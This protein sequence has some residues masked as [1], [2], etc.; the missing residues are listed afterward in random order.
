MGI[1]GLIVLSQRSEALHINV[2]LHACAKPAAHFSQSKR[3]YII[4]NNRNKPNPSEAQVSNSYLPVP[5]TCNKA[6]R[7][8]IIKTDSIHSLQCEPIN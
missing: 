1:D 4:I 8:M 5:E 7:F 3:N 6:Q 2:G